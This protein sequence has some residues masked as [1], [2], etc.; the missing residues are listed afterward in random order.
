MVLAA[1]WPFQRWR[2]VITARKERWGERGKA[3]ADASYFFGLTSRMDNV[4]T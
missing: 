2:E 3:E 1:R 4:L